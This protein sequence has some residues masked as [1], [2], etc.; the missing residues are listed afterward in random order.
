M[1]LAVAE[2]E[3]DVVVGEHARESLRD[4]AQ[5]EQG[6]LRHGA[7]LPGR[8]AAARQLLRGGSRPH[9]GGGRDPG[10]EPADADR[11]AGRAEDEILAAVVDAVDGV[12]GDLGRRDVRQQEVREP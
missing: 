12:T 6:S 4:P 7:I 5:L 3:V 9:G 11:A 2:I 1:D 10:I 8:R